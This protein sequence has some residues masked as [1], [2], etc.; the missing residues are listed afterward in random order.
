MD[1]KTISIVFIFY[2]NN[3][4]LLYNQNEVILFMNMNTLNI[5]LPE[6]LMKLKWNGQFKL[7]QEMIDLRLQKDIP[8][9]LKERLQLEKEILTR[10]PEDF[11]Y[12][13]EDAISILKSKIQD[14]KDEEFDTL[15]KDNAFEWIYIE[16]TMYFKNNFFENLIKVRK[17]YNA[18][19]IEKEKNT[20]TLLD[21]IIC[22]MKK[23]KDVYC[24]IHVQTSLKVDPAFEKPGKKIRVWLP[25]P[26]EYAQVE[27]FKLL[28][29]SHPCIVN[30]NSV[31][32][33]CIYIEKEYEKGDTFSVEY[34][35]INHMHYDELDP[36]L[37]TSEHPDIC[38]EQQ[39][40]HV[41]FTDYLKSL[42][43]E[44]VQDETNPL[45][46]A[47]K[48]YEYIT[49]HVMYSYVRA[50]ATLPSI[51]E[52][53]TTGLKGDCGLQALTFITL[54][55]IVGIPATWQ[56][57]L[58]STFDRIGNH[59]WARFYI[60]PY[61]WLYADCSFGGSAFRAENATR[62]DFYFGHLDP[63]RIPCSSKFQGEFVPAKTFLPNDPYDNQNG[64]MEYEDEAIPA[65]Y[66]LK[67]TKKID[68]HLLEKENA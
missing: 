54:C 31:D 5:P 14:F 11:I 49:S 41:L 42:A 29:T 20:S 61:G 15:F 58:Y 36:S 56:A 3:F 44:I 64:E 25:I 27:N 13:K 12:T 67:E 40:P 53:V 52:Y 16:G 47:K 33:R 37:V 32:Q 22:K 24:K 68:I 57:G 18:R 23:D 19:Y 50:Y 6:D 45:L 43:H 35:F 65:Q 34:E 39:A 10:L 63:F 62:R 7:M 28:N 46:K 59:D 30:D 9:K 60:A 38:L 55:R 48:I 4:I 21:D 26:K 51:P 2:E 1:S 17:E 8:E 66:I